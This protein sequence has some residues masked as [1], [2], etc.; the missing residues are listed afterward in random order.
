MS[1]KST[2]LEVGGDIYRMLT[3]K[4]ADEGWTSVR[5][6]TLANQKTMG[7]STET[8]RRVFT[9]C[10]YKG[11]EPFTIA[12]VM[13]HLNFS[14]QEIKEALQTYTSDNIMWKLIGD[15]EEP[16]TGQEKILLGMIRELAEKHPDV[17][18][19]VATT[20][21]VLGGAYG[22]DLSAQLKRVKSKTKKG[23]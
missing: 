4:L 1:G 15:E 13:L 12:N 9:A 3:D 19:S 20:L 14:R 21:A 7:L 6:F 2:K 16:L 5:H 11:I 23:E 17:Y 18:Q 8:T 22:L 10:E